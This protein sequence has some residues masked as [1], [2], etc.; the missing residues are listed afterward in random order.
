MAGGVVAC[1]QCGAG[2][3]AEPADAGVGVACWRCG[4]VVPVPVAAFAPDPVP[5]VRQR[6]SRRRRDEDEDDSEGGGPRR[7]PRRPRPEP[8]S[9]V[10]VVSLVLGVVSCVLFCVWPLTLVTSVAGIAGGAIA[11]DTASRKLAVSGLVL[12]ATGLIFAV[13]FLVL[14]VAG[15]SLIDFKGGPKVPPPFFPAHP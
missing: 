10:A 4:G 5:L 2:V 6:A 12:S 13:G 9:A 8:V 1:P 7:S 11:R 15:V 14:T 3:L